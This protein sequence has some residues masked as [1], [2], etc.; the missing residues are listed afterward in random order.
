MSDLTTK[1]LN[2]INEQY[3]ANEI[4]EKLNLSNK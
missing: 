1:L 2:L 4:A 3:T